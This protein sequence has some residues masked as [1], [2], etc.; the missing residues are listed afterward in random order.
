MNSKAFNIKKASA[1]DII[2][3]IDSPSHWRYYSRKEEKKKEFINT[4]KVG[5]FLAG[6]THTGFG[7]T[8][9]ISWAKR[10]Q[11]KSILDKV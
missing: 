10:K 3:T 11:Q 9:A 4:L 6:N 1:V 7:N 2:S 8:V 5:P